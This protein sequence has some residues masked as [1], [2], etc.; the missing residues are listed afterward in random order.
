MLLPSE[1]VS[2]RAV[3]V[4][5]ALE[6]FEDIRGRRQRAEQRVQQLKKKLTET[7]TS[8]VEVT[9]EV[10]D[11]IDRLGV[12]PTCRKAQDGHTHTEGP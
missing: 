3:Q 7:E 1:K 8:V 5:M 9:V 4:R 11:L 6:F 10:D 2:K 12:C